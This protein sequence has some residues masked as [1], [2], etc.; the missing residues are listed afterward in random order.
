MELG[1]GGTRVPLKIRDFSGGVRVDF[2]HK[3]SGVGST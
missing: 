1:H 2:V 3:D